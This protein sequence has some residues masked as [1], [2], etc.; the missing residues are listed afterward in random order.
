[1]GFKGIYSIFSGKKGSNANTSYGIKQITTI[2]KEI[3]LISYLLDVRDK[4]LKAPLHLRT[5]RNEFYDISTSLLLRKC[6][7][8]NDFYFSLVLR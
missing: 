7:T 3:I 8:I 4:H 5:K 6:H 1:M 2:F